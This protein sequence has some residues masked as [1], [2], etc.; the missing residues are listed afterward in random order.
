V[1]KYETSTSPFFVA[2][3]NYCQAVEQ[4]LK[5]LNLDCSGFCNNYG[6]D[7]ESTLKKDRLAYS[8]KLHKHQSTQQGVIIPVDAVNYC[9]TT[10][11]VVG[12]NKKFRVTFGKSSLRR[13]FTPS[14]FKNKL[15]A[16]YFINFTRQQFYR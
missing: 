6:Y 9:G 16:P 3:K 7:I 11:T 13:L 10:I 4:K 8:L 2:N 5:T 1:I 12:L 14:K 15:P